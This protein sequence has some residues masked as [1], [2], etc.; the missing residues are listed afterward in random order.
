MKVFVAGVPFQMDH[1]FLSCF[2]LTLKAL[3]AQRI[4]WNR[5]VRE[6]GYLS[7]RARTDP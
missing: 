7:F 6:H 1:S 5:K 4:V 3:L 2:M